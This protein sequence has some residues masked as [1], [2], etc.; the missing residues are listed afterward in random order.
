MILGHEIH[1]GIEELRRQAES[2]MFDRCKIER[3]D[4]PLAWDEGLKKSVATWRTVYPDVPCNVDESPAM[5]RQLITDEATT[6]QHPLI[7]VPVRFED[8]E[9]DDRVTITAIGPRSGA[10]VGDV[11]WVTHNRCKTNAA[12]RRLEC[13]W[14]R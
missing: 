11:Y 1:H 12:K 6:R 3:Q 14:L 9:N 4:G 7:R 5:A 8:V 10:R 2:T 13:R